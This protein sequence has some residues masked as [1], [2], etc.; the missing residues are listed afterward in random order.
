MLD[1]ITSGGVLTNDGG[2]GGGSNYPSSMRRAPLEAP[3][4]P[5]KNPPMSPPATAP[6]GPATTRPRAC[7]GSR[8]DH[9]GVGGWR[10]CQD[11]R[12]RLRLEE[13]RQRRL[14]ISTD[15]FKFAL[16]VDERPTL[17]SLKDALVWYLIRVRLEISNRD[18]LRLCVGCRYASLFFGWLAPLPGARPRARQTMRA[19]AVTWQSCYAR[20]VTSSR[21]AS[22]TRQR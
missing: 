18:L 8:T 10:S 17:I 6:T 5:A 1:P 4:R 3:E 13:L 16:I 20:S 15:P 21:L 22:P 7:A 14:N 11:R 9:I 19:R 2:N 12:H